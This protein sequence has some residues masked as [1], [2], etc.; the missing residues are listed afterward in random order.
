MVSLCLGGERP[1]KMI[2]NWPVLL[3]DDVMTTGVTF[4]EAAKTHHRAGSG[5]VNELVLARV[6]CH[7]L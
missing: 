5:P 4:C 3:T 1:A 2:A 6:L 7:G